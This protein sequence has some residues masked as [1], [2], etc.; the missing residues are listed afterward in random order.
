LKYLRIDSKDR[1]EKRMAWNPPILWPLLV[2]FG[3]FVLALLPAMKTYRRRLE[4]KAR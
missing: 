1:D 4:G 2:G 3:L